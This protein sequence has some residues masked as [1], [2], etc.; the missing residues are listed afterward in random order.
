MF[1]HDFV[2]VDADMPGLGAALAGV[3]AETLAEAAYEA[4]VEGARTAS[5]R[6]GPT[7][8]LS[9]TV[10]VELGSPVTREDVVVVPL[11]WTATGPSWLFPRMEADLELA[12]SGAGRTQVSF[13]GRYEPPLGSLGRALDHMALHRVAQATVRAFLTRLGRQLQSS[14]ERGRGDFAG[15]PTA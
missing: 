13:L 1:V 14:G 11:T 10:V 12:P 5:A 15:T 9:K 6:V 2:Y 4:A 8:A 3:R 7:G